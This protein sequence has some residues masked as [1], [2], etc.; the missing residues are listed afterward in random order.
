MVNEKNKELAIESLGEVLGTI[1]PVGTKSIIISSY[2]Y[3]KSYRMKQF[4]TCLKNLLEENNSKKLEEHFEELL[5][6][7]NKKLYLI[8]CCQSASN[9]SNDL[10]IIMLA[11]AFFKYGKG[12]IKNMHFLAQ[13]QKNLSQLTQETLSLFAVA[14]DSD[15]IIKAGSNNPNTK[16]L[17]VDEIGDIKVYF[18]DKYNLHIFKDHFESEEF[19]FNALNELVNAG[20][21]VKDPKNSRTGSAFSFGIGPNTLL[22]R[23]L[24]T[25]AQQYLYKSV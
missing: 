2:L 11:I 9:A 21:L 22:Y 4:F 8:D 1:L 23:E 20:M 6:D 15:N 16:R 25:E 13:A 17:E 5:A 3:Y 19:I 14:S 12:G 10:A 24:M 18:I 7:E